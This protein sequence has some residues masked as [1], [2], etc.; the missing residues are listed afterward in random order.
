MGALRCQNVSVM[1]VKGCRKVKLRSF[2]GYKK[3]KQ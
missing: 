1:S 2:M 3:N